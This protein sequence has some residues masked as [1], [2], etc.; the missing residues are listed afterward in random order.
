MYTFAFD[1]I[2]KI[3][4]EAKKFKSKN[5]YMT[6]MQAVCCMFPF[7]KCL[8]STHHLLYSLVV[9]IIMLCLQTEMQKWRGHT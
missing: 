8:F 1:S 3:M 2:F 4:H 9:F 7:T 5:T 6:Y